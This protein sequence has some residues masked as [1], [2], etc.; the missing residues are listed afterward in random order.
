MSIPVLL[1]MDR[2]YTYG[3]SDNFP[4]ACVIVL[5]PCVCV[6]VC[7]CVCVCMIPSPHPQHVSS[8]IL[9]MSHGFNHSCGFNFFSKRSGLS[10]AFSADQLEERRSDFLCAQCLVFKLLIM[11]S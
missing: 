5:I 4:T 8:K 2:Q 11:H 6:C 1:G 10:S 9:V 7:A 3:K